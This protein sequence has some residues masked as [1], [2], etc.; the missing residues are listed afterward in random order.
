VGVG[1]VF[2]GQWH[3]LAS[4]ELAAF[5]GFLSWLWFSCRNMKE[6]ISATQ[7]ST[8]SSST[9]TSSTAVV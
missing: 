8:Y 3:V 9:A 6:P 1:F 7:S 4:G 5:M 2:S